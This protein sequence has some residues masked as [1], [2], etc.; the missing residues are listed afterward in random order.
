MFSECT[1]DV[2]ISFIFISGE[3]VLMPRNLPDIVPHRVCRGAARTWPVG[4]ASALPSDGA[5]TVFSALE[6]A[7]RPGK[8]RRYAYLLKINV[9]DAGWAL[10]D[11]REVR[12]HQGS[13]VREQC[14]PGALSK[15][16]G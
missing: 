12:P 1:Q 13:C 11:G 8:A 9:L 4:R 16:F 14:L 3:G 15:A 10:R 5:A 2:L 7:G 6:A